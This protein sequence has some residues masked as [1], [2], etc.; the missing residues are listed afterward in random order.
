MTEQSGVQFVPRAIQRLSG[1]RTSMTG[2]GRS[3][4]RLQHSTHPRSPEALA[5]F[6]DAVAQS[7]RP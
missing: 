5:A 1:I 7:E 4:F 3:V 6:L 2:T